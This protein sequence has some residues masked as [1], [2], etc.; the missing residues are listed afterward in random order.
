MNLRKKFLLSYIVIVLIPITIIFTYR[1]FA[2][3]TL[4]YGFIKSNIEN[5]A[6]IQEMR[7][8]ELFS[9]YKQLIVFISN[10]E[11]ALF[12]QRAVAKP[13]AIETYVTTLEASFP[14][15][16]ALSVLTLEG[17]V[18]WESKELGVQSKKYTDVFTSNDEGH[19]YNVAFDVIQTDIQDTLLTVAYPLTSDAQIVGVLVLFIKPQPLYEIVHDDTGLGKAGE[20]IL[21]SANDLGDAVFLS[22]TRFDSAAALQRT[23]SSE[24]T[25]DPAIIALQGK[26]ETFISP[27]LID[28]RGR[29][30]IAVTKIVDFT[31]WG[32]VVK[33]DYAEAIAPL[34]QL[35]ITFVALLLSV[36]IVTIP[37]VIFLSDRLTR[38]LKRL[39]QVAQSASKG[40][41]SLEELPQGDDEIGQLSKTISETVTE[42]NNLREGSEENVRQRTQELEEKV[43]EVEKLNQ[44]MVGREMKMI[45]LKNE[46]KQ[47][48]TE[49]EILKKK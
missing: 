28:Y 24:N 27:P 23:I 19:L 32:F 26:E 3:R 21:V 35:S 20:I 41:S 49:I 10:D 7:M 12:S 13:Q 6:D 14:D 46:M 36:I 29:E 40:A 34:T 47:L 11:P 37:I 44:F 43:A 39:T 1:Y 5:I 45:E 22:P 8:E 38:P 17:E 31:Q 16:Y 2:V 18:V 48:T 9:K 33:V 30:V 4:T 25:N 42:L 15:V